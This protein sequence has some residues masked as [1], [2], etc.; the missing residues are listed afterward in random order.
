MDLSYTTIAL[1]GGEQRRLYREAQLAYIVSNESSPINHPIF[2]LST[3][4]GSIILQLAD[5]FE[6]PL[7]IRKKPISSHEIPPP[8]TFV[9]NMFFDRAS[10]REGAGARVIFMSLCQETITLFYK[11]EFEAT[12]NVAE[13]EA[14]VL[15]LRAAKDMGIEELVVFGYVELIFH[16][17]KNIYQ[18]KHPRLKT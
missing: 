3:D 5:S 1:F 17:V 18:D 6:A 2:S 13:Y 11:L 12:N 15:G 8:T 7:E 9:L 10:S 4:L 16:Q 14:L